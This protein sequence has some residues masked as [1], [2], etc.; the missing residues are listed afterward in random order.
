MV[1][2]TVYITQNYLVLGLSPS[3]CN[4]NTSEHNVSENESVSV[5][6]WR[7]APILLGPLERAN[8]SHSLCSL[9]KSKNPII[10]NSSVVCIYCRWNMFTEPLPCSEKRDTSTG[11]LMGGIYE[12]RRW[13]VFRCC[14]IHTKFHKDWFRHSKVDGGRGIH[15]PTDRTEIAPAY[16]K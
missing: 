1:L 14:D 8:L 5:V 4:L 13:D 7:E 15:R 6:R 9:T 2:A 12:V 3:S 16:R 10:L 11:R